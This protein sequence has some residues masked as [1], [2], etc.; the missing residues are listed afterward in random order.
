MSSLQAFY[1]TVAIVL[2]AIAI[3]VYPTLTKKK[4]R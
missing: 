2:L 1:L 3:V 4:K